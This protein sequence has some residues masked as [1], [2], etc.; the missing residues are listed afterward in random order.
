ML[1]SY[2][3]FGEHLDVMEANMLQAN[4]SFLFL[5][6]PVT[7]SGNACFLWEWIYKDQK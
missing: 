7:A 2:C 3:I 4:D 1:T 5:A 6:G